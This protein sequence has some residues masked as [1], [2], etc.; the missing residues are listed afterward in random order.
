MRRTLRHEV[1]SQILINNHK[2]YVTIS[3]KSG[4]YFTETPQYP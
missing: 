4:D 3:Q 1:V 2:E